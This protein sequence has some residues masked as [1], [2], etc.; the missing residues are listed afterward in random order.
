LLSIFSFFKKR[1]S[2]PC[3]VY[4]YFFLLLLQSPHLLCFRAYR[5]L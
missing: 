5:V 4:P 1:N 2:H 3:K